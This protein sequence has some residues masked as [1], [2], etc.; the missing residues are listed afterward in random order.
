MNLK[1]PEL[2]EPERVC[3]LA[4]VEGYR[5]NLSLELNDVGSESLCGMLANER[6]ATTEHLMKKID[7]MSAWDEAAKLEKQHNPRRRDRY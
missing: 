2:S 5:N 1:K 3:L 6:L 7:A 4:I